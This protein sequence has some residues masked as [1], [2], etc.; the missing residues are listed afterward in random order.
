MLG[1]A[2]VFELSSSPYAGGSSSA[3]SALLPKSMPVFSYAEARVS[4]VSIT[5]PTC[6]GSIRLG[7]RFCEKCGVPVTG[8]QK[9]A[10]R[11]RLEAS[12][13]DLAG[14]MK[15]VRKAQSAILWLALLFVIGGGL[16][17]ALMLRQSGEALANLQGLAPDMIFPEPLNG[18]SVTVARLRE[19]VEAEPRNALLLNLIVAVVM[20]GYWFWAN[21]SVL[22]AVLAA[23]LTFVAVHVGSAIVEPITL[24]QGIPIKI[25][26]IVI[27][28]RGVRS[29]LEARKLEREQQ[30][31]V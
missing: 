11:E 13:I 27:L 15:H 19:I 9:R 26:A 5:C 29:A 21:R 28:L 1:G 31:P 12:D 2:T 10:L 20:A 7:D 18:E 23:L 6:N 16:R 25:L 14:H 30:A 4:K 8:E 3:L 17:Y 24:V 22:P